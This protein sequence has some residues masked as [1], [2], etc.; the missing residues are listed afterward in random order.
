[1]EGTGI[2]TRDQQ[3]NAL[4]LFLQQSRSTS[5]LEY[6]TPIYYLPREYRNEIERGFSTGWEVIDFYLQG[7]R[8]GE[9]TVITADTGVGKTTFA[10]N[11]IVNCA[12]QHVP[13]WINSWE[14]SPATTMRKIASVVLGRPMK[15]CTFNEHEN[16]QFDEWCQRYKVYVNNQTV[17]MDVAKLGQQ[18]VKM[19]QLGVEVVMLD[20][21]D[22]LVNMRKEKVH[23]AI[24]ETVKRLH[25]L[26]F[27][28][29]MHL[30]LICHP[31]QT[32]GNEEIGMHMLRGSA[33]IKQY[34]DNII[35]LSRCSRT[36][37]GASPNKVKV[38]ITK[39]RMFGTEGVTYLYYQPE[40]D[41]YKQE[42]S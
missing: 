12:L 32:S 10:T 28:L 21:L 27:G 22:Y 8:K 16:E 24:D 15:V 26:A 18:L 35:I 5:S 17:G 37:P 19:R 39:N 14:M 11:L 38:K 33:S 20:H 4:E 13:V 41:G 36:D 9:V 6:A 29:D 31:K 40:W 3:D 34:A 23:E 25:E 2:P 7:I 1:M 42:R 30:L